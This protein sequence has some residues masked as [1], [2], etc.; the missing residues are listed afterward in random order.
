MT[1]IPQ[2]SV[3]IPCHNRFNYLR[4]CLSSVANQTYPSIDLI[5]VDDASEQGGVA[6]AIEST[7]W[8]A[9][10]S[11]KVIRSEKNGGAGCSRELGR[12]QCSGSYIAYL[13]SDDLWHPENLTLQV[14][15]LKSNP[16]AGMSYCTAIQ[17]AE[18][19][20][21]GNEAVFARSDKSF[22]CVLPELTKGRPWPTGGC[23][24]TQNAVRRI[25][26]W[27]GARLGAD[28]MYDLIAG[29]NDILLT[30]VPEILCYV[31]RGDNVNHLTGITELEYSL[32]SFEV[33]REIIETLVRT[34]K[35]KDEELRKWITGRLFFRAFELMKGGYSINGDPFIRAALK[36]QREF[37]MGVM[38][39]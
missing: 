15:N 14:E 2:V 7:R 30:K 1:T 8:H 13:D 26:P 33:Y 21:L 27:C 20:I 39:K 38:S 37:S 6:L 11:I 22:N 23:L 25:G 9:N 36:I 10:V 3:V 16:S 19:P 24:W 12:I 5:V 32:R 18:L 35:I 4:E 28:F 17:F 31:R 29:C 34:E